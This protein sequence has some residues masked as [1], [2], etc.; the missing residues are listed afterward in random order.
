VNLIRGAAALRKVPYAVVLQ[1]GFDQCAQGAKLADQLLRFDWHFVPVR[2]K[3]A[4]DDNVYRLQKHI[5]DAK[6]AK[7]GRVQLQEM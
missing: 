2:P 4:S 6:R 5:I 7:V 3:N 1:K